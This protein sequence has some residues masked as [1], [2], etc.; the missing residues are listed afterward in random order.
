MYHETSLMKTLM[1]GAGAVQGGQ[2]MVLALVGVN[3]GG[4]LCEINC[5]HYDS[6]LR[7]WF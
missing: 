4:N 1:S 2:D 7:S 3:G 6:S 5:M